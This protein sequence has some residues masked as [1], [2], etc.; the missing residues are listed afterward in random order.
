[1]TYVKLKL[2]PDAH[3]D[4]HNRE[5]FNVQEATRMAGVD[6]DYLSRTL[7]KDVM[8]TKPLSWTVKAQL[9]REAS[10]ED[11]SKI[12]VDAVTWKGP[13]TPEEVAQYKKVNIFD[14]TKTAPEELYP[15]RKF[16][17]IVLDKNPQNAFAEVEQAAFSPANV[18]PGWDISPDPSMS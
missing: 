10:L 16:G 11:D 12:M 17:K 1:M 4:I 7:W 14:A 9:F 5:N 8:E 2:V 6:P 3:H 18:V 15:F 13:K